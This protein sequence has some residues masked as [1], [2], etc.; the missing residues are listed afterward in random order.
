LP[1][2]IVTDLAQSGLLARNRMSRLKDLAEF[3]VRIP[4]RRK[5]MLLVSEAIG[6]DGNDFKDY[7]GH[8]SESRGGRCAR[9][10]DRRHPRQ[11]R[12]LSDRSA[13]GDGRVSQV[14]NPQWSCGQSQP[15][16]RLSRT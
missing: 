4:G 3:L 6:F 8:D 14:S 9:R 7:A 11:Y 5:A 16:R 13:R 10:D 12:D 1:D 15:R 2:S